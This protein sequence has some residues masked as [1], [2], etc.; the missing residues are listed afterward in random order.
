MSK[1]LEAIGISKEYYSMDKSISVLNNI[2]LSVEENEFIAI[3]GP[4]GSGKTTLLNC[5]SKIDDITIGKIMIK[6]KDI[7]HLNDKKISEFRRSEFGFIFQDF[8]LLDTLTLRENIM[9][10]LAINNVGLREGNHR[11]EK[12]CT[13]L[14]L[15]DL[16]EKYPYQVSGGEKQRCACA[17]A[18][19]NNPVLIFADEPTGALD[20]HSSEAVLNILQDMNQNMGATLLMVTHDVFTASYASRVLFFKDGNIYFELNKGQRTRKIFSKEIIE[21]IAEMKDKE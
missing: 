8:N 4:S 13:R 15:M 18:I 12:L 7:T 9:L 19:I 1:L 10:S 17:R 11:V 20:S 2:N 21:I 5:L 3:M 6:G 14:G 16:L